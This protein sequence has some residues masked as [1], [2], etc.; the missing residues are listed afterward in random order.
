MTYQYKREPLSV[1]EADRLLNAAESVEDRLCVWCLLETGLRVSELASLQRNQIQWQQR[2][3]RILQKYVLHFADTTSARLGYAVDDRYYGIEGEG[4]LALFRR[5]M[6]E[7]TRDEVNAAIRKYLRFDRLWIAIVTGNAEGLRNA[8][9]DNLP[10][11]MTYRSD[12]PE[13]VLAEDR[14]IEVYPLG[15]ARAS[16]GP[17]SWSVRARRSA[18]RWASAGRIS[19]CS[20]AGRPTCARCPAG[21][22]APPSTAP[23]GVPIA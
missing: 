5:T 2:A 15:V 8:L 23:A 7:L 12:K 16:L 9:V 22:S 4:H 6:D 14:Q 1:E 13:E 20:P 21:S 18:F 3:I 19:G 17:T 11:P 10:S